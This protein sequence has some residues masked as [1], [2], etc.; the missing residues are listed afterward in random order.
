MSPIEK[1]FEKNNKG[2]VMSYKD[3]KYDK[4]YKPGFYFM[5][6]QLLKVYT[7]Q[8]NNLVSLEENIKTMDLIKKIYF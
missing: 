6:K 5:V 8:K 3:S 7:G 4:E 1:L 2:Q